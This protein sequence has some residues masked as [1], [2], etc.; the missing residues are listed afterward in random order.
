M[1]LNCKVKTDKNDMKRPYR[2]RQNRLS[3]HIMIKRETLESVRKKAIDL[4]MSYSG[5]IEW[6]VECKLKEIQA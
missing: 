5:F 1:K 2:T 3:Y 6:A 4:E